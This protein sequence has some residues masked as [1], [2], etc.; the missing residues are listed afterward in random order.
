[1]ARNASWSGLPVAAASLALAAALAVGTR[2]RPHRRVGEPPRSAQ[3][4]PNASVLRSILLDTPS[5]E[6]RI[7][8]APPADAEDPATVAARRILADSRAAYSA[9]DTYED[10]G[11]HDTA[12]R[13]DSG[14]SEQMAF[15][16]AFAGPNAIRFAYSEEA[17]EFSRATLTQLIANDGGV[18][19]LATGDE[20]DRPESVEMGVATLTG[21]SSG[22]AAD[23]LPLLLVRTEIPGALGV[24]EPRA[25]GT[26]DIEGV[27][28]DVIEGVRGRE[29]RPDSSSPL[30]RMWIGHD[31][32][33]IRRITS[34]YL[35]TEADRRR[36]NEELEQMASEGGMSEVERRVLRSRP[37]FSTFSVTTFHPR[38][39]EEVPAA[40]LRPT[41]GS[42]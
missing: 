21:V 9:C 20:P 17:S 10:D 33:L 31:D 18:S 12:F 19:I 16:T 35:E 14:Y 29:P 37:E 40:S 27:L 24:H 4:A 38:C 39:N 22:V 30:V 2:S 32:S 6:T 34:D 41:D 3:V 8:T 13:R 28:C 36:N 11:T 15:R 42:L 5:T 26:D 25:V 1:M 7:E 23:V